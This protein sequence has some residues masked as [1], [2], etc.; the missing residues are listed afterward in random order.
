MRYLN[1][2][3]LVLVGLA[4]LLTPIYIDALHWWP[5]RPKKEK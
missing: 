2:I 4:A 5:R 3:L 1:I